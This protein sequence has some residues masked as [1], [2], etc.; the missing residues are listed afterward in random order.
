MLLSMAF[1]FVPVRT[2][3]AEAGQG[4]CAKGT[5]ISGRFPRTHE[6]LRRAV[7]GFNGVVKALEHSMLRSIREYAVVLEPLVGFGY[8]RSLFMVID[9]GSQ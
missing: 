1:G 3:T 6:V 8:G 5:S 2:A 9:A 4:L 7:V